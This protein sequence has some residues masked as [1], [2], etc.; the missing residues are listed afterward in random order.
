MKRFIPFHLLVVLSLSGLLAP[1]IC[2]SAQESAEKSKFIAHDNGI[3][4]DSKTGLE[5]YPGPDKPTNWYDA[6]KW[7]DSLTTFSG[8]GWR[9]P[10]IKELRTLYQRREKC[11]IV[12]F[13]K[14]SGCWV[15]SGETKGSSLAWGY[16]YQYEPGSSI[17]SGGSGS[18]TGKATLKRDNST[19]STRGFAV[20]SRK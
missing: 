5:W 18:S 4:S 9:M 17:L 11:N 7:V 12:P 14:T 16:D 1:S 8:G 10:T 6:K 13:L 20:R 15:W 19:D 3:V 2:L